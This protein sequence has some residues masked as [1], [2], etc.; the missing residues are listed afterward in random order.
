MLQG[1]AEADRSFD[2]LLYSSR[3][4]NGRQPRSVFLMGAIRSFLVRTR[5]VSAIVL[6]CDVSPIRA[7]TSAP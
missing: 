2:F 1:Q 6:V 5:G 4:C 7:E 3:Q